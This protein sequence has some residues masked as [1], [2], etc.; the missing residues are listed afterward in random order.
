MALGHINTSRVT[1]VLR[2]MI[3][4]DIAKYNLKY[5]SAIII[6]GDESGNVFL[7][8]DAGKAIVTLQSFK[9]ER[10]MDALFENIQRGKVKFHYENGKPSFKI[11]KRIPKNK[12]SQVSAVFI[13]DPDD[14]DP[15]DNAY[16]R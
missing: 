6:N 1:F 2:S 16:F 11:V 13:V 8:D 7:A 14:D 10:E 3:D 4:P 15:D 9:D 5:H 12:T